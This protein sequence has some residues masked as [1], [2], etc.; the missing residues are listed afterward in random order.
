MIKYVFILFLFI[1][2]C[3]SVCPDQTK[4]EVGVTETDSKNDKFQEKKSLTQTWKWGKSK[5]EKE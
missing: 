5:C 3:N 4:V 2:G 1:T